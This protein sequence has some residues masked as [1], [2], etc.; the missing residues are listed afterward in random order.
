MAYY[1]QAEGDIVEG[2]LEPVVGGVALLFAQG[3]RPTAE[4][5]DL[6]LEGLPV[7]RM[8]SVGH[9]GDADQGCFELLCRGLSF[10]LQG[11]AP[12]RPAAMPVVM[13]RLG[14]GDDGLELEAVALVA[15][16]HL[17]GGEHLSPVLRTHLDVAL[18]LA[19]LPGLQ[20]VIWAPSG[21]M[22][23]PAHF[24][25]AI[26]DWLEGGRF[27]AP[28]LVALLREEDGAVVSHGLSFFTPRQVR[29]EAFETQAEIASA[30]I[31]RLAD[32][33]GQVP[34]WA[35]DSKGHVWNVS[36]AAEHGLVTARRN[37]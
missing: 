22:M 10:D 33:D 25:Q 14:P 24:M 35:T 11:L 26:G 4:A 32:G 37:A 13:Q 3:Q 34:A 16:R 1:D 2:V 23:A 30:L 36:W 5:I 28:G 15:G 12:A 27:P 8:L 6:L 17:Q 21:V 7:G 20:A 19:G 9:R 31:A 29:V 18:T